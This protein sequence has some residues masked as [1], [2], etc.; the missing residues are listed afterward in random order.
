MACAED[1]KTYKKENCPFYWLVLLLTVIGGIN[2]G[3]IG[4]LNFNLVSYLFGSGT[5]VEKA[6]YIIVGIAAVI[7][8]L[9]SLCCCKKSCK[10]E[11]VE[12]TTTL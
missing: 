6:V 12:T 1:K 3:L 2:W 8:L 10:V 11:K 4:G 9:K 7:L 5:P